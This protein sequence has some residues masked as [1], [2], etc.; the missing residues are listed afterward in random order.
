MTWQ[1][2]VHE[3]YLKGWHTLQLLKQST[4]LSEKVGDKDDL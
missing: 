1:D 2:K 3:Y 4:S